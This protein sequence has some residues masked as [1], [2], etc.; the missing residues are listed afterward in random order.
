MRFFL[1][2]FLLL[3]AL[4]PSLVLGESLN[5]GFVEGLWYSGEPVTVGEPT[6]IYVA[7]RNNTDHDLTGT[8]RFSDNGTRIGTSYVNALPGRLVEAWID[9]TPQYGEH[10]IVATLSDVR[11]HILGENPGSG[12]VEDTIAEDVLFADYDTDKDGIPNQTDTDDDGDTVS[13]TD[14]ITK[15]TDPLKADLMKKD[16]SPATTPPK[17]VSSTRSETKSESKTPS[18]PLP[19]SGLEKY[20]PEG[21][22]RALVTT[23]TDTIIDTKLSLDTYRDTRSDAIK[24][25]LSQGQRDTEESAS[26]EAPGSGA[27]ITRTKIES[28][29]GGFFKAAIDAGKA[30]VRGSYSLILWL[31]SVT[32]SHP[33]IL[34]LLLLIFIISL[35][36]RTARR[37]GRRRIPN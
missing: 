19:G 7:L 4:S 21:T 11:V 18:T 29:D 28:S 3:S 23:V 12:A 32:L 25:Y 30:L 8:V 10:K 26:T 15:G 31:A 36:Y 34:E 37:L 33:A 9:W 13:D 1:I 17:E 6:R 14:E 35:I 20:V 22:A 27:A 16:E 2:I 24:E 5:A